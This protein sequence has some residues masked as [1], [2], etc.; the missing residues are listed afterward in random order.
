MGKLCSVL[1]LC[2]LSACTGQI[3]AVGDAHG[4]PLDENG[5]PIGDGDYDPADPAE[6]PPPPSTRFARLS[7]PQ[8]NH[9]V[10]DLLGL[11]QDADYTAGFPNDPT[12]SGFVFDNQG[13]TAVV[14]Q[15]LWGG[16]QR[17]AAQIAETVTTDTALL[18]RLAPPDADL[19]ARTTAFIADFGLHA[20]RRP[21]TDAQA[22]DYRALFDLGSQLYPGVESF[23]A[24]VR[25][26]IEATLQSPHF[27]YR[28]E[29]STEVRASSIPLDGYEVASRLSY[30]LWNT[31][32]DDALLQAAADGTL[33]SPEGVRDQAARML[34]D[35]RTEAMVV[36]FH[37][38]LLDT[39]RY[40][41][42]NPAPAFYSVSP[43]LPD[44]ALQE[45]ERFVREIVFGQRAGLTELLT[46]RDTFVNAE[47]AAIYG[48]GLDL[49]DATWEKV[50][51]DPT[52][53]AGLLTQV[54]F[55]AAHATNVNP[56]PI[57]RGKF[58]A[59]RIN[60]MHIN[61]PPVNIPPLP[62]PA[63]RTN[64]QTI[65]DHTQNPDTVCATCHATIINPFGFPFESFDA[66]GA[67]RTTDMD[68]PVDTQSSP[69]IDG[70]A[71]DVADAIELALALAGSDDVHAC[72]A[73]HWIEFAH[74][75][76]AD[77]ADE[78]VEQHLAA[79]SL[80]GGGVQD[81]LLELVQ[82]RAFLARAQEE[83]P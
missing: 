27:V 40:G 26:V 76:P 53:R 3:G 81:L 33:Q 62:D 1:A 25:L 13:G 17:A 60:C 82:T 11:P 63:G 36:D 48:L 34:D 54:G 37:L 39:Q 75:R 5:D 41:T 20:H 24:G 52:E 73:R 28:P 12:Q 35:P 38:Q 16:Y 68:M 23:T 70:E 59:E 45:T 42:I 51:L 61:A 47:L 22:S 18:E 69:M 74:G 57:H 67:F 58:I 79:A 30:L 80:S 2:L 31:M 9:S 71:T 10:I 65:E 50:S 55:L 77:D 44:F 29:L 7:H 78:V 15:A 8:W 64:R 56:D 43:E 14:D 4:G 49:D 46:S 32:P 6:A 21:L 19:E 66:V 72:Y 83:L